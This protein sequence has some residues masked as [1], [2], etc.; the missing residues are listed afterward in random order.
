MRVS[1][2]FALRTTTN[3]VARL[4]DF[5]FCWWWTH[6]HLLVR[7]HFAHRRP[8]WIPNP[9]IKICSN[10]TCAVYFFDGNWQMSSTHMCQLTART[11][12]FSSRKWRSAPEVEH[13]HARPRTKSKTRFC[14]TINSSW[15]IVKQSFRMPVIVPQEGIGNTWQRIKISRGMK[16]TC[17]HTHT[18]TRTTIN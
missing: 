3:A 7:S 4:I 18:N 1:S 5:R 15:E 9:K 2:S 11:S 16:P 13:S 12:Q 6:T 14:Q 17:A 10:F 8:N